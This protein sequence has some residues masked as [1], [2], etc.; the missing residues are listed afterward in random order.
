MSIQTKF[1][2][3]LG[4]LGLTV[5]LGLGAAL[6]FGRVLERE[7]VEP[8]RGT[9]EVMQSL[10]RLKRAVGELT[11]LL[12][13]PGRDTPGVT[14]LV[15]DPAEIGPD[16]L[17]AAS[18]RYDERR[19]PVDDELSRLLA[20]RVLD[21]KVG[22]STVRNLRERVDSTRGIADEWFATGDPDIGVRAGA[23]HYE[24]HELIEA[25]ELR[26]LDSTAHA[27]G[28][29]EAMRRMHAIVLG[30]GVAA[31]LLSII[32]TAMLVRRWIVE[33]VSRLREAAAQIARGNFDHPVV[34]EG[35]DEL[36]LLADEVNEMSGA[37][38]R[39]QREAVERERLAA[40][41]EM[42]RRI[43]H[44]IRN[45]L[46]G[47]RSVAELSRRRAADSEPIRNDQNEIIQTVDRFNQWLTELLRATSPL[48]VEPRDTD[49][50]PWLQAVA[51]SHR[52]L[53]QMRDVQLQCDLDRCPPTAR[54]DPRHLEHA[55]VAIL[56]NAIQASPS[57]ARVWLDADTAPEADSWRIR[58]RDEG[59]GIPPELHDRIFQPYFTTKHDGNGI[60]LA[61]TLQI[62]RR[63]GGEI[64]LDTAVGR[65]STFVVRLPLGGI[66]SKR[67]AETSQTAA[68][69]PNGEPPGDDPGHRG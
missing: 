47:I 27:V 61:S 2:V 29:T 18:L 13:G 60:G 67:L 52:A 55:V 10:T 54:F 48:E 36:A 64:L 34:V 41:G 56:T 15:P 16:A 40:V 45:P 33:P 20:Q 39:M 38:A 12:P 37:I 62:V 46:A 19:R 43:A 50:R 11:R 49:P 9:A 32:L 23:A 53:A 17:A 69:S 5:A 66:E 22:I 31:S 44:N 3:L 35:G 28:H 21:L 24:I 42:V 58:V 8:F 6:Y 63:H 65:G 68:S 14:T 7:M 57:G 4:S 1:S 51:D 30:A 25:I 26:M 59:P